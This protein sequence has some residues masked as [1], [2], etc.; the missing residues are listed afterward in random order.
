MS[1]LTVLNEEYKQHLEMATA[2][3]RPLLSLQQFNTLFRNRC[4]MMWGWVQLT[5]EGSGCGG[6]CS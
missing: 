6:G 1:Q 3:R 5:S 2:S 4:V